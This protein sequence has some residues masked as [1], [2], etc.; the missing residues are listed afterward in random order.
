ML[1]VYTSTD[2]LNGE[3]ANQM[4]DLLKIDIER[5][6]LSAIE[7]ASA[8]TYFYA[9]ISQGSE[10]VEKYTSHTSFRVHRHMGHTV[11]FR[12]ISPHCDA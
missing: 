9:K 1:T 10:D 5:A 8:N 7:I 6:G 4:L 2:W 12:S 3:H 11:P